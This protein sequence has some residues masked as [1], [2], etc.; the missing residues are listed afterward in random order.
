MQ[1][2]KKQSKF[3][4]LLYGYYHFKCNISIIKIIII[5]FL[6]K[7]QN[8]KK[9]LAVSIRINHETPR[10]LFCNKNKKCQ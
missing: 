7:M 10:M 6:L 9:Q 4:K 5:K 8:M 3:L 1:N 2:M